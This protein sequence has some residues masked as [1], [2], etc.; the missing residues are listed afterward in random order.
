LS[1]PANVEDVAS[2][3][4]EA[5]MNLNELFPGNHPPHFLHQLLQSS[6][7]LLFIRQFLDPEAFEISLDESREALMG[8]ISLTRNPDQLRMMK[9]GELQVAAA[10]LVLRTQCSRCGQPYIDCPCS[11]ILDAD[12]TQQIKE[13]KFLGAFW[14]NRK[15]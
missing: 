6:G 7:I 5:Y 1:L 14:T 10:Y 2:W 12:V 9:S 15:V 3:L 13:W 8:R 4:E 11:K